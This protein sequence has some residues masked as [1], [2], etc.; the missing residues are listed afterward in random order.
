DTRVTVAGHPGQLAAAGMT[1]EGGAIEMQRNIDRLWIDG[2]GRMTMPMT[3]D[4]NG[5]PI[6]RPQLL[7]VN[8]QG[9]MDFQ[10]NTVVFSQKVRAQSANQLLDTGKLTAVLSRPIDFANPR[11]LNSTQPANRPQLAQVRCYGPAVLESRELD[12]RG[13]Q[14][15]FDL[16]HAFDLGIDQV[17]GAIDGRGP[18]TV[19]HV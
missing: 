7:T 5:R 17:T 16:L 9:G 15:A 10:S 1:L 2:P 6:E 13:V 18:G 4:L 8:W 12:E 19:T 14:T 11:G 3:Q